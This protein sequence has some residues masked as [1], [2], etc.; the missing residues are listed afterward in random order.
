[1]DIDDPATAPVNQSVRLAS[2]AAS[3]IA[4]RLWESDVEHHL[5]APY[6]LRRGL[7]NNFMWEML[8]AVLPQVASSQGDDPAASVACQAVTPMR[9]RVSRGLQ[10][11]LPHHT[12]NKWSGGWLGCLPPPMDGLQEAAINLHISE[13]SFI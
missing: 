1:M 2:S 9:H 6:Q 10:Q 7:C 5:D 8:R 13:L 3:R 4:Q 12:F 11:L